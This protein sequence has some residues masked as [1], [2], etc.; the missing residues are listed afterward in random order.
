[1]PA[2]TIPIGHAGPL[3]AGYRDH[4]VA[5]VADEAARAL[6][7]RVAIALAHAEVGRAVE[8]DLHQ[9]TRGGGDAGDA[10]VP[11]VSRGPAAAGDPA[12][13]IGPVPLVADQSH[14]TF[15][16][17]VAIPFAHAQ[18]YVGVE[19]DVDHGRRISRGYGCA[20][21]PILS[22][23]APAAEDVIVA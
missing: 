5:R 7:V 9:R 8:R 17:A 21:I 3:A 4:P 12:G 10:V 1:M 20:I 6:A 22:P 11:V 16:V 13:T 19:T 14:S 23:A 2:L 18:I 15:A